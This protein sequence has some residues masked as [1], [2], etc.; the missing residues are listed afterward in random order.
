MKKIGSIV[1]NAIIEVWQGKVVYVSIYV[2]RH[3]ER[4]ILYNDDNFEFNIN[5]V[6]A[7]PGF[8]LTPY[9]WKLVNAIRCYK[10]CWKFLFC[11]FF[12]AY[13]T[14]FLKIFLTRS[15]LLT[16]CVTYVFMLR[17]NKAFEVTEV[18]CT[19]DHFHLSGNCDE[20]DFSCSSSS[21]PICF[22]LELKCDGIFHCL[23]LSDESEC[24]K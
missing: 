8:K 20:S 14:Y 2:M 13:F 15:P 18:N 4:G 23:D 21:H 9:S 19:I 16:C 3:A 22:K 1:S 6:R 11:L 7:F 24:G 12:A 5:S 17:N 10:Y